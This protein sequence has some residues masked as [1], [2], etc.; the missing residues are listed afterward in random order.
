[1]LRS[2]KEFFDANL[3]AVTGDSAARHQHK[4]Q[5]ATA[6][7][8]L[9]V[10]SADH[11]QHDREQAL[12]LELLQRRFTLDGEAL[13]SLALLAHQEVRGATSL[14]QFTALINDGFDRDDKLQLLEQLWQVAFADGRIDR[15]EEHLIR[16]IADLL[17]LSHGDFIRA[18][19]AA[20]PSDSH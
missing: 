2:I 4:L 10:S 19:L 8:L 13:Q 5:L 11:E 9:E 14:Y 3:R 16:K 20:K 17:Y 12:L 1:M 18:K 6:A 7:L 15:Y